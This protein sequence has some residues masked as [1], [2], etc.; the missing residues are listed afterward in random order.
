MALNLTSPDLRD[1]LYLAHNMREWDRREV[2]ATRWD[3]D[4]NI[5]AMDVMRWGSFAH[6]AWS[7]NRPVAAIGAIEAWPTVWSVWMFGTDEFPKVGLGL[8]RFVRNTMIP[9]IISKGA[10]RGECKSIEGHDEA[11]RWLESLG[12]VREGAP[13]QNYGKQGETFHTYVWNPDD[14]RQRRR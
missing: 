3:D 1:I 4:P 13:L 14:V 9:A 2:F 5:L 12:A 7:G 10:R 8:T 11:H 6:V